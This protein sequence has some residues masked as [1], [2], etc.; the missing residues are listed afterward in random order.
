M[1]RAVFISNDIFSLV[2]YNPCDDR[3]LYESWLDPDVQQGFNG[4]YVT[5]FD[6]FV[7]R[8]II[9]KPTRFTAM[10]RLDRTGEIIGI[11]G[12]SPPEDEA[13]LTIRIFKPHRKHGYGTAAFALATKYI[14][15][16][17]NITELHAGAYPD[18]IGSI[19]MLERCGYVPNPV[20]NIPEKHYITGEDIIQMDYLYKPI[21]IRL[22]MPSDAPD[23]AEVIIRSWEVAYKDIVP[24]EYIKERN[25]TRM[26]QYKIS[27]ENTTQYVIQKDGKTVGIITVAPLNDDDL[28]DKYY[29]LQAIYL[30]P[31]YFRQGIG[32]QA[33][34]F[35]YDIARRLGKT[36]MTVWVLAENINAIRFYEKCGFIADGKTKPRTYGKVL[37]LIRMRRDL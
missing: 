14:V 26:A 8:N 31:D 25:S 32:T 34:G 11:V 1:S 9:D 2:E 20:G 33:M 23:M 18:N 36:A 19:K 3:A 35:A 16:V 6:D 4:V 13:D 28:G 10:I 12:I 7:E 15:E 21:T 27:D 5:S 24:A 22:A 17:L 37:E 30:H 29:D